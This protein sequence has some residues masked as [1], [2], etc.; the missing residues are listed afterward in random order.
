MFPKC[1]GKILVY[2]CKNFMEHFVIFMKNMLDAL[3]ALKK[4]QRFTQS[5][6]TVWFEKNKCET[7]HFTTFSNER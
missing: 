5:L 3:N 2:N 7:V 4:R 6:L 1:F